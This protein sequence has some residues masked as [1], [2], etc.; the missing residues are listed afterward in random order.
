MPDPAIVTVVPIG[1]NCNVFEAFIVFMAAD[2]R[3]NEW[4]VTAGVTA[5]T[6]AGLTEFHATYELLYRPTHPSFNPGPNPFTWFTF[7]SRA[8]VDETPGGAGSAYTS[9]GTIGI[10]KDFTTNHITLITPIGS[11][12]RLLDEND[13]LLLHTGLNDTYLY[14]VGHGATFILPADG[15]HSPEDVD[16]QVQVYDFQ[17]RR[18]GLI[19]FAVPMSAADPGT[20]FGF[21]TAGFDVDSLAVTLPSAYHAEIQLTSRFLLEQMVGIANYPPVVGSFPEPFQKGDIWRTYTTVP[22]I[23]NDTDMDTR[24]TD[25][26]WRA[27][28]DVRDGSVMLVQRTFDNAHSWET[29]TA[30]SDPATSNNSPTISWYNERLYLTWFDGT[31]IREARSLDG[32]VHWDV[33]TTI[34]FAGTNPRRVVDRTGGGTFYFYFDGDDLNVVA[35][36]DSG[37]TFFGPYSIALAVGAQQLDA[38]F[39]PDGSLVVSLFVAGVWTQYRSRDL[40]VTWS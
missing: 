21:T 19:F 17:G 7:T 35:S 29:W 1:R 23:S 28:P 2:G 5:D 22:P 20:W 33:P 36:Y 4:A 34:P 11:V 16:H 32:G 24:R 40:A 8:L 38:E 26:V 39:V 14:P 30:F 3:G 18:D 15:V 31:N 37:A 6:V 10:E 9:G 25:A 27:G 12:T 13:A